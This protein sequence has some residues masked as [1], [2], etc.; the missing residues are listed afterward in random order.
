MRER[1]LAQAESFLSSALETAETFRARDVRVDVS[2]GNL[3]QL[4][5]IYE[6]ERRFAD[7]KRILLQIETVAG[8]RRIPTRT[9]A[10]Y[11][12][13][14]EERVALMLHRRLQIGSAAEGDQATSYDD[15]IRLAADAFHV[16]PALVKA[17]VAAESNFEARAVSPVGAQGLMQLMP[18][19]ARAMGV[20][21][22]FKPSENIEGGV[23][24][25]RSLLDRFDELGLA[26]AAYNAGPHVVERYGGIPPYP[27]TEQYVTRVLSHYRRYRA[28]FD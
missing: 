3:V 15:L 1:H 8:R 6:C 20:R 25:L 16:D 28:S 24:Y 12:A 22:P 19:T 10:R 18:E 27:E 21:R 23:R 14:Y 11:R 13:R 5:S 26:L 2:F 7:A 4:A 17:V 9:V